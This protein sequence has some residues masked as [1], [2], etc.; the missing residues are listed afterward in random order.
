[1]F[2]LVNLKCPITQMIMHDPVNTCDGYTYERESIERW[3]ESNYTNP[4]TN[5]NLFNKTLTPNRTLK[6]I[7]DEYLIKNKHHF[8]NDS[9][10]YFSINTRREL[11]NIII[12]N[13]LN[14]LDRVI[15]NTIDFRYFTDSFEDEEN[16][17]DSSPNALYLAAE[18]GSV[19][20]TR[21]IFEYLAR[22]NL[23]D[24]FDGITTDCKP[25]Y[26][27][28]LFDYY[29][30]DETID[31]T[32]LNKLVKIFENYSEIQLDF[33]YLIDS[34]S[35]IIYFLV[36][37]NPILL[38]LTDATGNTLLLKGAVKNDIELWRFVTEKF[39]I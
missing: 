16:G 25:N 6:S 36:D 17:A 3:L 13:D 27:I 23:L 19:Q 31:L 24:K 15:A 38:K 1:M 14:E 18:R 39:E 33:D 28:E 2:G 7:I 4:L 29:L 5:Q 20:S 22:E 11:E 34:H 12:D 35:K 32:K 8:E 30:R 9:D 10:V 37:A 26:L 21:K